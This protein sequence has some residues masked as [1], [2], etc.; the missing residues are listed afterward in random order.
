[1]TRV[2]P[3]EIIKKYKEYES[4]TKVAKELNISRTTVYRWIKRAR[5]IYSRLSLSTRNLKRKSTR[6]KKIYYALSPEER[7]EIERLRKEFGYC[8]KKIASFDTIKASESTVYRFMKKK[9]LV[10]D[11]TRHRRP[12][13][14]ETIHMHAKNAK[15]IGYLQMDVKYLEPR[16]TGL[17]F[18]FLQS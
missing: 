1:M 8:A 17:P 5:S 3:K 11:K 9:G 16:I 14:Q 13:N 12:F 7:I 4:V 2:N 6:P 18:V 10:S 15:T